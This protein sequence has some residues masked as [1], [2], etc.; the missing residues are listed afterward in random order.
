MD[1]DKLDKLLNRFSK[2]KKDGEQVKNEILNIEAENRVSKDGLEK[3]CNE[4]KELGCDPDNIESEI[5]KLGTEVTN[6]M[7]ERQE[8][9]D[10]LKNN[11]EK[12]NE[13]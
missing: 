10:E 2:L 9:L 4:V 3:L 11:I 1:K 8:E 12:Y 7:K 6:K 5:K 13:R